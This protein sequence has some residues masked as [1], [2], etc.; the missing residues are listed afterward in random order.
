LV[1]THKADYW[2]LDISFGVED[3]RFMFVKVLAGIGSL[4]LERLDRFVKTSCK[5]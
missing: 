2:T 4:V 3:F 1:G 5:E